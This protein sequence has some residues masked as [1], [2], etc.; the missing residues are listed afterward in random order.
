[1]ISMFDD[2][3]ANGNE[4]TVVKPSMEV[5]RYYVVDVADYEPGAVYSIDA[6]EKARD[7]FQPSLALDFIRQL[8][9]EPTSNEHA[10]IDF[11]K[12]RANV[13]SYRRAVYEEFDETY[14]QAFGYQPARPSPGSVQEL[15]PGRTPTK[16][17]CPFI[18]SQ[19]TKG[20]WMARCVGIEPCTIA[21]DLEGTDGRER[22][23][24][25]IHDI[26]NDILRCIHHL[27]NWP[28][29]HQTIIRLP[30]LMTFL[31]RGSTILDDLHF[32]REA[33]S[34]EVFQI[35]SDLLNKAFD[36]IMEDYMMRQRP[37]PDLTSNHPIPQ[38]HR[39]IFVTFSRGRPLTETELVQYFTR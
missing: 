5:Q 36:D 13:I 1:M 14:A 30:G 2:F 3:A 8:A 29:F 28:V 11:I 31:D 6:I 15:P 32:N 38:E 20:I 26:V 24:D 17:H 18:R 7:S 4:S 37:I 33:V 35:A 10:G 27:S 16:V 39:T 34:A 19:T 21:M 25:R 23:E 22:G 12:N 9:L